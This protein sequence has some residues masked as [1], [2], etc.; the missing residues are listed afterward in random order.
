M[1]KT[2]QYIKS[3]ND[4]LVTKHSLSHLSVNTIDKQK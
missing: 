1:G 4:S 3:N 2:V